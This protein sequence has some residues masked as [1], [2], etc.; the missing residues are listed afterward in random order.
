M[1]QI[2][3]L[4]KFAALTPDDLLVQLIGVSSTKKEWKV[5]CIRGFINAADSFWSDTFKE[6]VFPRLKIVAPFIIEEGHVLEK[7]L[8]TTFS[9]SCVKGGFRTQLAWQD[10]YLARSQGSVLVICAVFE[11]SEK[12]EDLPA[13]YAELTKVAALS[14]DGDERLY[15]HVD[16]KNHLKEILR[17]MLPNSLADHFYSSCDPFA[18]G[19]I[20]AR[21]FEKKVLY[22]KN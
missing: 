2:I 15:F 12:P 16:Q 7:Y 5:E 13:F 21:V 22:D 9:E 3:T 18:F 10:F 8:A 4:D 19:S 17:S 14:I 1:I 20:M 6:K 11:E